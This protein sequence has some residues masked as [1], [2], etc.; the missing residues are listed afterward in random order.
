M[1]GGLNPAA[2]SLLPEALNQGWTYRD[3]ISSREAGLLLTEVY[4]RRHRHSS[5]AVWLERLAAGQI[6]RN[7][8]PL[9]Q[10]TPLQAGDRLS[11]QRPPWREP[12]VPAAWG[13][14]HDDGDLLVIDKPNGLPV[15]PAGG[16]L[17]H[18]VLRLLER[19]HRHD[20]AGVPRPVHRLGRAT[21]GLLVC[22]RSPDTRARLSRQLRESTAVGRGDGPPDGAMAAGRG[23]HKLYRAL[24]VPGVLALQPG[25]TVVIDTPIGRRP[26]PRLGALWCAAGDPSPGQDS[27]VLPARSRLTLLERHPQADLV[28]VAIDSGRPHQIRIHCAALGAPLLGDPLYRPGGSADPQALPGEGGYRL[29]AWRLELPQPQGGWLQLEVPE[30]LSLAPDSSGP[31]RG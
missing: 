28:Q 17:E 27:A 29:Q 24:L 23:V 12:A 16:F 15:L 11:W 31:P 20:P 4:A 2:A 19:R 22:A 21:S 13:V 30:P 8:A 25:Q 14:V 18:T 26:H 7:G 5:Q 9:W 6:Q 3:R 10:D 1:S